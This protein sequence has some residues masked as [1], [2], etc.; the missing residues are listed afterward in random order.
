MRLA[1]VLKILLE[2][3]IHFAASW[4]PLLFD[5]TKSCVCDCVADGIVP[6]I[7]SLPLLYRK[8]IAVLGAAMA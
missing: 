7:C 6:D 2:S 5:C 8:S 3:V 1:N 4:P